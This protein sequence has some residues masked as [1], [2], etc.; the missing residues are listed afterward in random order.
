V[1]QVKDFLQHFPDICVEGLLAPAASLVTVGQAEVDL[2]GGTTVSDGGTDL[3]NSL[4][5]INNHSASA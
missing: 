3:N 2:V 4:R 5:N 1:R